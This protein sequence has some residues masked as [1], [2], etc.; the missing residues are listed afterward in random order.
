[1]QYTDVDS[2]EGKKAKVESLRDVIV[3][4][5]LWSYKERSKTKPGYIEETIDQERHCQGSAD[6]QIDVLWPCN[7]N[8]KRQISSYTTPRIHTWS[9]SQR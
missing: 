7:P 6:P 8:G 2:K 5:D 3:E 1:M 9:P 4:E